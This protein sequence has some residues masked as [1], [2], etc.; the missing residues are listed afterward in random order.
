MKLD[1]RTGSTFSK[2]N[3]FNQPAAYPVGALFIFN[4]TAAS[5]LQHSRHA[6]PTEE[7]PGAS[8]NFHHCSQS[9]CNQNSFSLLDCVAHANDVRAGY[10]H[11]YSTG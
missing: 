6:N 11:L 5:W 10:P 7:F 4:L 2:I 8:G 1:I 9:I 3:G